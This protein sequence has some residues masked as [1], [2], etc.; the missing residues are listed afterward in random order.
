MKYLTLCVL[1]SSTLCMGQNSV[2]IETEG[3]SIEDFVPSDWKII[4]SATGDLNKD[5]IDDAALVIQEM[6]QKNI[7]FNDGL[8]IDTLDT[9]PRILIVLFKDPLS[10]KFNL[11][12]VSK[13]FILNHYS[14]TMDDPF[15]GI[16]ISNGILGVGFHFWYNAGSW[17]Q[18][19]LEYKFRYDKNEFFLIGAEFEE[20]HRG[21]M[22]RT[23]RS[24]NFLTKKM[25]ETISAYEEELDQNGEQVEKITTVWKTMNIRDG[26]TIKTITEPLQWE[27]LPDVR[28]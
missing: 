18:T 15:D 2:I 25:S 19:S 21:T 6:N 27:V 16:M 14:P 3:H 23:E 17:Y 8:G 4:F 1:I 9:N 13:T 5:N 10:D 26:K 7:Q 24:F 20:T 22:E 28:I 12:D 11:Q